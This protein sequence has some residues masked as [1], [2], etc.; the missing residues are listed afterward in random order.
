MRKDGRDRSSISTD[1]ILIDVIADDG[2]RRDVYYVIRMLFALLLGYTACKVSM[3]KQ[4]RTSTYRA[5]RIPNP[6]SNSLL[7]A[8]FLSPVVVNLI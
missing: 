2:K 7:A 6:R 5:T 8:S 4:L 3:I 1:E